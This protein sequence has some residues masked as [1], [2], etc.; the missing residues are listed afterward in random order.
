MLHGGRLRDATQ[1]RVLQEVALCCVAAE[2]QSKVHMSNTLQHLR[3]RRPTYFVSLYF[4]RDA[5]CTDIKS[6]A[7]NGIDLISLWFPFLGR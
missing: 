6:P 5:A 7:F 2:E 4:L 3:C 1:L